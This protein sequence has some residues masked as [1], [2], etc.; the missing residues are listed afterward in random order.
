MSPAKRRKKTPSAPVE[1]VLDALA[2]RYPHPECALIHRNPFELLVATILS[3]QT[4]D[5][6]VNTVTP[7]LFAAYPDAATLAKANLVDL[8][9]IVR[10]LGFWRRRA[11]QL[12]ELGQ[13]LDAEYGGEVPQESELLEQLP[14]V[15]RKTANVVRGNCF[16]QPAITVDTHVG[17]LAR[18]WGWTESKNPVVAEKDLAKIWPA[19]EL[20]DICHRVILFGREVCHS[21]GPECEVCPILQFCPQIGVANS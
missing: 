5:E 9:E 11:S 6:R 20:T 21:R 3:A 19:P 13:I 7:G 17:R 8:Q 1:P 4:T 12:L 15:G 2:Q 16:N 18:R 10:P 14:G